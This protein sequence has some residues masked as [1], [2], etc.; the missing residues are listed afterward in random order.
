MGDKH[1]RIFVDAHVFDG[2]YQGTRTFIKEL[3]TELA[4]KEDVCL[5]LAARDIH[6][7][8]RHFPPSHNLRLIAYRSRSSITRLLFEIPALIRRHRIHYA[9]FQYI[10]PLVKNCR[11]IITTH[12]VLFNEFPEEFPLPYRVIKKW[13]YRLSAGR[14]DLLTTVS[15][16]SKGSI[17]KF[18]GIEAETIHVIPN[19]IHPQYFLPHDKEEARAYIYQ[20]Y[21][22]QQFLL[23]T[24]RIEPRKNH[25]LLLQAFADLQLHRDYSLVFVGQK[26]L[27]VPALEQLLE[28][29]PMEVKARIHFLD[30]VPEQDL[31]Q[32]YRAAA[33]FV[34][35]SKAEGFGIPPLEAAATGTPV[36]CSN[37]AAMHAYSFFGAN[38]L[39]PQDYEAFKRS[40]CKVLQQGESTGSE[41]AIAH[42]IQNHYCWRQS[43][44]RLYELILRHQTIQS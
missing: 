5:Y 25:A 18:L 36:I 31:L 29:L 30:A 10:A 7:L 43:A 11:F 23:F 37:S 13:L 41:S 17:Q 26:S 22:I 8:E 38:H 16:Y 9:H 40:L 34:Y 42:H 1:I 15:E 20:Q 39:D 4:Q 32:M 28:E 12:D 6:N 24:S 14:A 35:P 21:G 44:Q 33:L 2:G 3:Y 19:G 27:A